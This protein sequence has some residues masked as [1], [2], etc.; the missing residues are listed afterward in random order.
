[1]A[2]KTILNS[3]RIYFIMFLLLNIL[4]S[5]QRRKMVEDLIKFKSNNFNYIDD[6][7]NC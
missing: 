7:L 2:V 1:M 3:I 4:Y 5:V 6:L